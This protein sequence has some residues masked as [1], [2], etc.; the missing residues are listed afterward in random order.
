MGQRKKTT[1]SSRLFLWFSVGTLLPMLILTVILCVQLRNGY[2]RNATEQMGISRELVSHYI[3]SYLQ[4][5]DVVSN[6][7]YYH[8]YFSSRKK[9]DTASPD[10]YTE[11]RRFQEE[12]QAL[13]NTTTYVYP[14]ISDQMI[15]SDGQLLYRVLRNELWPTFDSR[16]IEE[17]AWFRHGLEA[18]GRSVFTPAFAPPEEDGTYDTSYFFITRKIRNFWQPDQVNMSIFTIASRALDQKFQDMSL[19]Y[20]A[21]VVITNEHDE[22]IYSSR[23]LTREAFSALLSGES[24]RYEGTRWE[25]NIRQ[26]ESFPLTI[27]LVYSLDGLN[28]QLVSMIFKSCLLCLG[29]LGLVTALYYQLNRW[30]YRSTQ[31]LLTTFSYV[32]KGILS[33]RCPPM[34]IEEFDQLG[35][36]LNHMITKLNTYI[37]N[38][39]L[40]TIRQK[41]MQLS[42]LQSQIQPHFLINTIYSFIALN[43]IGETERLNTAF[44]SLAHMMRYVLSK[45][46]FSTLDQELQFLKDYLDLQQLRFGEKIQYEICCEDTLRPVRIPRLLLQPLVE[47]AVIHGI[48]PCMHS[49][50]CRICARTEG[51]N[52]VIRV[53]DDGVG[54]DPQAVRKAEEKEANAEREKNAR[55]SV[56]LYYVRERVKMWSEWAS[57]ALSR[58]EGV[59]CAE[60]RIPREEIKDEIADC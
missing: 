55:N 13:I 42:A 57:F 31:S 22:L 27:R 30:I 50:L 12:M 34:E 40:M 2:R 45:E 11:L 5:V 4:S 10:Y 21:F 24:Y 19:L 7:P 52:L 26:S 51:A 49:C 39:Y 23:P 43:Q 18:G 20:D 35:Q 8:S 14:N 15:Y 58:T 60:I 37:K 59:T 38:E 16:T 54:F 47:N 44:Y 9:L 48:E 3:D 36:S 25:E 46:R 32:E 29:G 28:R 53:T 6:A 41:S 1:I 17:Q 33:V 56:G